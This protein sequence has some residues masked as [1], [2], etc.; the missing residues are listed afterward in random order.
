MVKHQHTKKE[1]L[2]YKCTTNC[3]ANG[4]INILEQRVLFK[5]E[6]KP[7]KKKS[8][9]EKN[10]IKLTTLSLLS[11]ISVLNDWYRIS[12]VKIVHEQF[13]SE[14]KENRWYILSSLICLATIW[15]FILSGN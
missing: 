4:I 11:F 14:Y 6:I 10:E 13:N 7:L 12:L 1:S 5:T 9:R 15:I 2:F 3:D 8:E